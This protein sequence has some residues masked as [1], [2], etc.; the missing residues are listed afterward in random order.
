MVSQASENLIETVLES[1]L[2]G[3]DNPV[4]VMLSPPSKFRSLLGTTELTVQSI[5]QATI[6]SAFGITPRFEVRI[7]IWS[8]QVGSCTKV[9]SRFVADR[10]DSSIVHLDKANSTLSKS[11]INDG[12]SVPVKTSLE[13]KIYFNFLIL[14][15]L[16]GRTRLNRKTRWSVSNPCRN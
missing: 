2:W 14:K 15:Y 6:P 12:M 1:K 7:G 8:P 16:K 10:V 3:R 13:P 9:H 5:V 4:I 11:A